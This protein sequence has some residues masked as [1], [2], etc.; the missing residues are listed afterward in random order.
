M[1]EQNT[2]AWQRILVARAQGREVDPEDLAEAR[3]VARPDGAGGWAAHVAA[4]AAPERQPAPEG[5]HRF[6][7]AILA[8]LNRAAQNDAPPAA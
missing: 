1:A 4:Q 6:R 8:R 7:D 5:P 2:Q 3:A